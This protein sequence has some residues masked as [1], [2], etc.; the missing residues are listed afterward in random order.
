MLR[1]GGSGC[2][3]LAVFTPRSFSG[4]RHNIMEVRSGQCHPSLAWSKQSLW[5]WGMA[6]GALL[7]GT[8]RET[9][10]KSDMTMELSLEEEVCDGPNT[11][12]AA[13]VSNKLPKDD[14]RRP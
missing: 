5:V 10:E 13:A 11:A 4:K 12:G 3:D 8:R 14:R 7:P 9:R 2:R 6:C 1:H